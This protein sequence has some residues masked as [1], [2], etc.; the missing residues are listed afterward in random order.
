TTPSA[1][2]L[3]GLRLGP[4]RIGVVRLDRAG[5]LRRLGPEVLLMHDAI[6][7]HDER[8]DAR[9]AVHGRVRDEREP[10]DHMA[11]SDEIVR[12]ARRVGTLR[13]EDA[14]E[15]PVIRSW[16]AT[17]WQRIA[18]G[19]CPGDERTERALLLTGLRVPVKTVALALGALE[20]LRVFEKPGAS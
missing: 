3:A 4:G 16:G 17:R 5:R 14:I 18:G 1:L 8:H 15:V 9:G 10:A 19:S 12:A 20:P 11:F 6:L 13:E 2:A 7:I